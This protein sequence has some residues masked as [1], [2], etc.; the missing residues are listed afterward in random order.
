M[1]PFDLG[2]AL[3]RNH[4]VA[5]SSSSIAQDARSTYAWPRIL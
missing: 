1:E 3:F 5:G 2:V 4:D